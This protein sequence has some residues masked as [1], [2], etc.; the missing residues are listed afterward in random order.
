MNANLFAAAAGLLVASVFV[1]PADAAALDIGGSYGNDGG[2]IHD[3]GGIPDDMFVLLRPD[4]LET[5]E[6]Y[7]MFLDIAPLS[8]GGFS[9][10]ADCAVEGE[11]QRQ[12][13]SVSSPDGQGRLT[14]SFPD[15]AVCRH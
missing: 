14:I 7:C 2:C 3:G 4:L 12:T 15:G 10:T 5:V 13:F 6:L 11:S 9:V 1:S 8:S